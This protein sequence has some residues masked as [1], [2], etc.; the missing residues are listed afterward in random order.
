MEKA[1]NKTDPQG[2]REETI[3]FL[4][5]K[6]LEGIKFCSENNFT[7]QL[8]GQNP[9]AQD[10]ARLH[11]TVEPKLL[12]SKKTSEK[13]KSVANAR[14]SRVSSPP[15]PLSSQDPVPISHIPKMKDLHKAID[16][17]R[18]R[19]I[20]TEQREFDSRQQWLK[21]RIAPHPNHVHDH[22][23]AILTS[24]ASSFASFKNSQ[25][26]LKVSFASPSPPP[27]S[28]SDEEGDGDADFNDDTRRDSDLSFSK[29]SRIPPLRRIL[30]FPRQESYLPKKVVKIPE[31]PTNTTVSLPKA[32][33]TLFNSALAKQ[34][35]LSRKTPSN[36]DPKF[37]GDDALNKSSVRASTG[38]LQ[39]A[40]PII[41]QEDAI[42]IPPPPPSPPVSLLLSPTA[43]RVSA[44]LSSSAS[45]FLL[46]PVSSILSKEVK[47]AAA[48][49]QREQR[50]KFHGVPFLVERYPS[51]DL[52][53]SN[54]DRQSSALQQQNLTPKPF[55]NPGDA[56]KSQQVVLSSP[57]SIS[58]SSTDHSPEQPS[59]KKKPMNLSEWLK[60][61]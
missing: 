20:S 52:Q 27:L 19:A 25:S 39:K 46:P 58:L 54:S 28:S 60:R 13:Q 51:T 29:K 16:K 44:P 33:S 31:A 61:R 57:G 40:S 14:L 15:I 47:A 50:G 12:V 4:R 7:T 35:E 38:R 49:P 56:N 2:V 55:A 22:Q 26:A 30:P 6:N 59:P 10:L 34:T 48:M 11:E 43:N 45:S 37:A 24:E 53:V 17:L 18:I 9:I 41:V 36:S 32:T 1:A 5:G 8:G 21:E 23:H 42:I 3:R